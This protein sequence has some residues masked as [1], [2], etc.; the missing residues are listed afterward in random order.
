[1]G[2]LL[3]LKMGVV[4]EMEEERLRR[5]E[6]EKKQKQRRGDDFL[7]RSKKQKLSFINSFYYSLSTLF[8]QEI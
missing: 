8:L 2:C 4:E 7:L 1:M 6:K 3:F 5:K